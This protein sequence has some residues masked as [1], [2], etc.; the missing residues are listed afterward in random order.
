M[1]I[2]LDVLFSIFLCSLVVRSVARTIAYI[3]LAKDERNQRL[4]EKL[5]KR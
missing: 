3:S 2:F 4:K 1:A 5:L